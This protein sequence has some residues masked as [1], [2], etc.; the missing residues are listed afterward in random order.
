MKKQNVKMTVERGKD[1]FW[2]YAEVK[3]G[4]ITTSGETLE[5]L[6]VN[7]VEATNL[8]FEDKGLIYSFEE[9]QI[10]FDVQ[11]FFEFY[12][13]INAKALA[14]KIGMSQSLLAQY[15]RGIK[16]PSAKQVNRIMEGVR[17]LGKELAGLELA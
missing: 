8:F 14:A 13:I 3:G 4:V 1:A 6:K 2:A 10:T 15:A 9:I 11:S 17:N 7:M 16:K 12:G 5:E